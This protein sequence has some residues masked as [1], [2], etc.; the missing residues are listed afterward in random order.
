[1]FSSFQRD[2]GSDFEAA[3]DLG[4][5]VRGMRA[6]FRAAGDCGG[7]RIADTYAIDGV[8]DPG[9]W[10]G[11]DHGHGGLLR[12]GTEDCVAGLAVGKRTQKYRRRHR[13]FEQEDAELS[14]M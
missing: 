5:G 6:N 12:P 13:Q 11:G 1:V 2:C 8:D 7:H 9:H 14:R 10:L 3:S 4:T